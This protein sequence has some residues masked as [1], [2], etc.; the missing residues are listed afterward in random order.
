MRIRLEGTEKECNT[1]VDIMGKYFDVK[2]TS[3]FYANNRGFKKEGRVY[4]NADIIEE[5]SV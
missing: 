2:T 4:I 3:R 5:R 1:W